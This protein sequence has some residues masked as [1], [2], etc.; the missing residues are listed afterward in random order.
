VK[1]LTQT[2]VLARRSIFHTFRQPAALI[3]SLLFPLLFMAVTTAGAGR[4]ASLPEFP[5]RSY[6][7]FYVAGALMQGTLFGGIGAG[8]ALAVDIEEGFIRRLLLTPLQ[9]PAVLIAAAT[10]AMVVGAIQASVLLIGGVIGGVHVATGIAGGFVVIGLAMLAALA[11][12]SLGTLIATWTGSSEATQT[13]FP[14]FFVLMI[15]SSYFMPRSYLSGW[16]GTVAT[17]NPATYIIEAMRGPIT[18]GWQFAPILHGLIAVAGISVVGFGGAA[19]LL[20]TRLART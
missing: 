20:R 5:A 15:F 14:F 18:T 19:T 1:L 7:D 16:F 12:S 9:R 6:I 4:I 11:F 13:F 8:T 2:A 17:Y 3:P 10:G